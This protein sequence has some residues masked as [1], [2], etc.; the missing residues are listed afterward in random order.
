MVKEKRTTTPYIDGSPHF[1]TEGDD[2]SRLIHL[3]HRMG[4]LEHL[5]EPKTFPKN[6]IPVSY[7]H[8]RLDP[9]P[10]VCGCCHEPFLCLCGGK[11]PA[12]VPLEIRGFYPYRGC[13]RSVRLITTM[14]RTM[15]DM[16]RRP[17]AMEPAMRR[18]WVPVWAALVRSLS[19][20]CLL[21][22]SRCV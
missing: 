5:G 8:L 4:K 15:E 1:G 11:R 14:V 17:M 22:T 19:R 9:L 3:R 12:S 7:T 20:S 21:Y 6:H 18:V 2:L 13:F 10:H 16:T